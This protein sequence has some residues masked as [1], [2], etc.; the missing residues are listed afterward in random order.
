MP[1]PLRESFLLELVWS[2]IPFGIVDLSLAG[3]MRLG[4]G[5]RLAL[6]LGVTIRGAD[7]NVPGVGG[8]RVEEM[9]LPIGIAGRLSAPA[10]TVDG[11][12]LADALVEAGKAELASR[13]RAE[14]DKELGKI[15][16][17]LKNRLGDQVP[18]VGD[19]IDGTLNEGLDGLFGKKPKKPE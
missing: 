12:K 5:V 8:T 9:S 17:D 19:L 4:D 2:G 3:P 16:D 7:I 13:V 6:D 11:E 14:A 10:I 18:G 1:K 15:T